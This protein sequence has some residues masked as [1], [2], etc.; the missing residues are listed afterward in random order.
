MPAPRKVPVRDGLLYAFPAENPATSWQ[1]GVTLEPGS[2]GDGGIIP[3]DCN[4]VDYPNKPFGCCDVDFINI[5]PF[6]VYSGYEFSTFAGPDKAMR[7][8]EESFRLCHDK[9]I[10]HEFWTGE[11]TQFAAG[12][13]YN[14]VDLPMYLAKEYD[15]GETYNPTF[16]TSTDPIDWTLS[17]VMNP[18]NAL[19][20]AIEVASANCGARSVI[21]VNMSAMNY[22]VKDGLVERVDGHWQTRVGGHI[23]VPGRGYPGTAPDGTF[24]DGISWVYV[25]GMVE[26]LLSEFGND[27]TETRSVVLDHLQNKELAIV[28]ADAM[29]VFD[30]C[31]WAGFPMLLCDYGCP[32][33]PDITAGSVPVPFNEWLVDGS[34]SGAL[35][36]PEVV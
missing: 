32:E 4:D 6:I 27:Y 15:A 18:T 7:A 28:E 21:H 14:A 31:L 23:V 12:A 1:G 5:R 25:T 36:E 10:E 33:I 22:W 13:P 29:V 30:P 35:C 34:V 24:V 3:P 8:A 16:P 17:E 20:T 2:C 26:V 19:A 9:L 11:A